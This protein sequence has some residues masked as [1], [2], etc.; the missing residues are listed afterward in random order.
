MKTIKYITGA[1]LLGIT[2]TFTSCYDMDLF[3]K[4]QLGPDN[5]WK[6]ERDIQMGLTGVYAQMKQGSKDWTMFLLDGITDDAYCQHVVQSPYNNLQL[7]N[8]EA[9]TGG[10]VSSIYSG[11][12]SGISA[13]HTFLKNFEQAKISAGL[14]ESKANEYEA[15]IRFLRAWCYF[16]LLQKYGDIPLYKEAI[17][18]VEASKVKQSPASEV[19]QFIYQ[20]LEFAV[21]H[22]PNVAYGSGHAVKASAQGLMARVA[23]FEGKWDIV[24]KQTT[25]IISS[26]FYRLADTYESIFIKK[27][28]QK[29]NPEI[30]FSVTYLN[31]DYRHNAEQEYYFRNALSPLDDLMDQYDFTKDKRAKA[32]YVYPGVGERE[33]T[34]PM[35]EIVRTGNSTITGWTCIKHLDKDDPEI[36]EKGEYDFRT[37]NDIIV[38]RYADI[39]LMYIEAMVEKSGGT[40][41]DA[42]A[43]RFF[44]QIKERAGLEPVTSVTRD[45]LRLERRRELAFE[46]RR[47][48]DLIR[49]KTVK[50]V[51]SNLVT[52]SGQ[53]TFNDKAYT[54]PFPQSEMD[55]NPN[56]DQ[57]TVY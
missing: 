55:I 32:W 50:E 51:M 24:E 30:L 14:T 18:S 31:P 5:F 57:K 28:G 41:S 26:G 42:N 27:R 11:N 20:D 36:Y 33:W 10:P 13:C 16:E 37:D 53:C 40:T 44:N 35:G 49:W 21:Q 9:A 1:I 48:F 2:L 19:Y 15:E 17:E 23:L 54:W 38:I 34:N 12:Y 6:T 52:P 39:Y 22:L 46:G 8:I 45:E 47:Y 56:L 4:T 25:D 43:V 7:G 29:N 3:P